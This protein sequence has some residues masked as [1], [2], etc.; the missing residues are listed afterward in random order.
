M[1]PSNIQPQ[2]FHP[3]LDAI[4]DE[5]QERGVA[6]DFD[7]RSFVLLNQENFDTVLKGANTTADVVTHVVVPR[8]DKP[9]TYMLT[10]KAFDD[11]VEMHQSLLSLINS[12]ARLRAQH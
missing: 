7:G 2:V 5:A 3:E 10:H 12:D 6:V 8:V 1:S 4:F 11:L 9:I